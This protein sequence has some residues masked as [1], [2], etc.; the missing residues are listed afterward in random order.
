[1]LN[2]DLGLAIPGNGGGKWNT[3][4][5]G[6]A[7][8]YYLLWNGAKTISHKASDA[9]AGDLCVWQTH[10]GIATGGGNMISALN[11]HLGTKVTT[12]PGGSPGG[13]LLFVRRIV[14]SFSTGTTQAPGTTTA[15]GRG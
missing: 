14:A 6:P 9:I 7:T 15:G 2:H 5:H 1:V 4:T 13:E 10:M 12:I 11:E 8:G 3:N